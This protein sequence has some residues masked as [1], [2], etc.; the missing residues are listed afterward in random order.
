MMKADSGQQQV[1]VYYRPPDAT[2]GVT[3]LVDPQIPQLV[4]FLGRTTTPDKP[5]PG[6]GFSYSEVV[7]VLHQIWRQG[8]LEADFR[9]EQD[10]ILAAIL[11]QQRRGMV[12]E[13]PEFG[14]ADLGRPEAPVADDL[15]R[16]PGPPPFEPGPAG[17]SPGS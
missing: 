14:D 16:T 8:Y 3:H 5:L 17:A 11:A 9:P 4:D 10:R 2:L 12:T 1:E 7:S 15:P 13:R 6:L